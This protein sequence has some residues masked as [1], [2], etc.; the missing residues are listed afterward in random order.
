MTNFM[1]DDFLL[2]NPTG[3]YLFHTFAEKLPILDYHCHINPKDIWEDV[4]YENITRLWICDQ[5]F[6]DHYKWR[7]MRACGVDENFITGGASDYEKFE[8]WAETLE[9][10]IGNPVYSFSHLELRRYFGYEGALNR[11]TCKEVWD[12]CNAKLKDLSARSIIK[13]SDVTLICTTDDPIDSLEYH[14]KLKEDKNFKTQVL[15]A[16][17]P[18]KAMNLENDSYLDYLSQLSIAANLS[19]TSFNTLTEALSNRIHY[20][21]E[22]GCRASDHGLEYIMFYP[23]TPDEIESIFQ[24]RVHNQTLSS[25]EINQ[26]KTAFMMHVAKEYKKLDW[27]MQLH[28][29]CKRNNNTPQF[30]KLGP[31]TGYDTIYNYSSTEEMSNFFDALQKENSLP[32]TIVYSLNPSDNA[33]IVNTIG[34]FQE[35]KKGKMQQGSAWWFND[36]KKGMLDQMTTL[37]ANGVLGNFLGMLTDSRSFLSYSRHEYFRRL[38]CSLLGEI[39]ESGEYPYDEEALKTIVENISYYNALNYFNFKLKD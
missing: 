34:C 33:S 25:K 18:D 6:G 3:K 15:P 32:K 1:N 17:R 7:L 28:Y 8:K 35:G 26:F 36:H 21:H 16:F 24:K 5:G 31:D 2:T 19:I 9:S 37:A 38:L 27:G 20:F 4:S 14:H 29:G 11:K 30:E 39:V 10:C 12:L 13:K 23:A 22:C